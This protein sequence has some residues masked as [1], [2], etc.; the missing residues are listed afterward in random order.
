[1]E[2]LSKPGVN[3]ESQGA[4]RQRRDMRLVERHGV[5]HKAM[6]VIERQRHRG[7]PQDALPVVLGKPNVKG[8]DDL[9]IDGER[10]AVADNTQPNG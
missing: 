3:V 8:C 4:M 10:V 6:E 5:V 2:T 1:M 7:G 9:R